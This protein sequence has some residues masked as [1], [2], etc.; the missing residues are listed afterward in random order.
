MKEVTARLFSEISKIPLLD[1]HTH[2]DPR[3]PTASDLDDILGYHYYTEL[4][5]SAGLPRDEMRAQVGAEE[6]ARAVARFLP[7]IENTV[8][9]SWLL[10]IARDLFDF[11]GE[12]IDA[13]SVGA[14]WKAAARILERPDWEAQ[15]LS[16]A[17][18]E[19]V[20]LTNDFDDP[21]EGFD[22]GRYVP[23]LRTDD[24]VFRLAEA[25]TVERLRRAGNCDVGNAQ[26]FRSALAVVFRRFV[27]RGALACAISLPGEFSPE[28]VTAATADA[29]LRKVLSGATPSPADAKIVEQF[30]F[31]TI[32]E[33]C[34]EHGLPFDLMIGA[35]RNVYP[36]GVPQGR[37][38]FQRLFSLHQYRRLFNDFP[39]VRFPVSVIAADAN[40]EL[41]AYSWIFPNV[42]PQGHWWYANLPAT[43]E[44]DVRLRLSAVPRTKLLGYYSDA[45]KLEFVL[46]KFNMYR[47]VLAKV[48][49][50]DFVV[51][52]RW[53]EEKAVAL[54]RDLLYDNIRRVFFREESRGAG[55]VS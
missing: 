17:R 23:C 14:L 44:A 54:A 11:Q 45:Y 31:R 9:Y 39:E 48:L 25:S 28:P 4:A 33:M 15:L 37:D 51:A 12:A 42:F 13:S 18:I 43:I 27:E 47:R 3:R 34:R 22:T 41:V 7:A 1:P 55:G 6:R 8:Q 38:L 20:F 50:E 26:G 36:A 19:K 49:A 30:A 16:R 32:T 53:S 21:L 5:H 10:E 52:R 29:S 24:L 40:Q 2:V 46:P 35:V